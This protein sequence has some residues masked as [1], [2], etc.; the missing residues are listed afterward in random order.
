MYSFCNLFFFIFIIHLSLLFICHCHFFKG[1]KMDVDIKELFN[2]INND[3]LRDDNECLISKDEAKII[4][5]E[6]Y[7]INPDYINIDQNI[8]FIL[9]KCHPVIY[10]PDLLLV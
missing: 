5:K 9:G 3:N 7:N 1:E 2:N 6:K 8:R 10:I 4:L